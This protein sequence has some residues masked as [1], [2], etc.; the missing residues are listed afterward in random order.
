MGEDRYCSQAKSNADGQVGCSNCELYR[1]AHG[2]LSILN[3][4]GHVPGLETCAPPNREFG[5]SLHGIRY[6]RE[7][8]GV[9]CNLRVSSIE[10]RGG[11][12]QG[13]R[14]LALMVYCDR[15]RALLLGKPR[16][17]SQSLLSGGLERL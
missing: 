11:D 8:L 1:D 16:H 4:D 10:R 13:Y 12:A 5:G 9:S 2:N 6:R 17:P 7:V 3:G 14:A 15:K